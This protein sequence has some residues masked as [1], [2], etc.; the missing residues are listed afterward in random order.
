MAQ[1]IAVEVQVHLCGS[2]NIQTLYMHQLVL[3]VAVKGQ[4]DDRE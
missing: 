2:V 1:V 4:G 3:A